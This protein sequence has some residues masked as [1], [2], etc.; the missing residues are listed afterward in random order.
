RAAGTRQG[1]EKGRHVRHLVP[2]F[3]TS[4]VYHNHGGNGLRCA[5]DERIEFE[6]CR[7]TVQNVLSNGTAARS[8]RSGDMGQPCKPIDQLAFISPLRRPPVLDPVARAFGF[9]E[10]TPCASLH[11]LVAVTARLFDGYLVVR[12]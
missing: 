8:R 2:S 1:F 6:L 3:P 5:G 11:G 10:S 7:R 9:N 4:A 12:S